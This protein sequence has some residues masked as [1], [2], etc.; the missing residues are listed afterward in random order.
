MSAPSPI[1]PPRPRL[2]CPLPGAIHPD[3]RQVEDGTRRWAR[4]AGLDGLPGHEAL[5]GHRMGELAARV[6]PGAGREAVQLL[7]DLVL[8][9]FHVDDDCEDGPLSARPAG[10]ADRLNRLLYAAEHPG[11]ELLPPDPVADA[12]RDLRRRTDASFGPQAGAAWLDGLRVYFLSLLWEAGQ[13]TAP[14]YPGIESYALMRLRSGAVDVFLPFL[15]HAHGIFLTP[16]ERHDPRLAALRE[17]AAFLIGWANDLLS[18]RKESSR[19]GRRLDVVTLLRRD[20]AGLSEAVSAAVGQY[21]RVMCRFLEL[22]ARAAATAPALGRY[23]AALHRFVRGFGE[24]ELTSPRYGYRLGPHLL[25]RAF[26]DRP[27]P[28]AARPLGIPSLQWWWDAP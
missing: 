17:M 28:E 3:H 2:F 18:Y 7:G 24:W 9:L 20:G 22:G 16:A 6:L 14:E 8:W 1:A 15:E 12:V 26:A 25:A 21:D 10:L 23:G 13:R 5:L 27:A 4:G 19:P 11:A